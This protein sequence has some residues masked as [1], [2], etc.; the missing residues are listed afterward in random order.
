MTPGSG[1]GELGFH[2][3][4]KYIKRVDHNIELSTAVKWSINALHEV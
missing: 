3:R 1:G 4:Q 2:E